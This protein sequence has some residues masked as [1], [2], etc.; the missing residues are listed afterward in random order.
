MFEIL[1]R[2]KMATLL[3]LAV[4]L[5]SRSA[6]SSC[7]AAADGSGPGGIH[8][9]PEREQEQRRFFTS[10][11]PRLGAKKFVPAAY[12]K[13][14]DG[15]DDDDGYDEPPHMSIANMT[16]D[17]FTQPLNHFVPRGKS[18]TFQQRYCV[19]D[20][21]AK[22][23]DDGSS[24]PLAPIL[25]Y[26]GNESPLEQY[27]NHTGLMWELAPQLKARVVFAEHRYEGQSLP[28]ANLTQDCMSYGSTMQALADYAD[29]LQLHLNSQSNID[30]DPTAIAPVIVFGGSYG[31]MLSAWMRMKYPHL[32]AGAI[33]ASAPIGGFP[34]MANHKMDG[35]ARVLAHGLQQS[36]PPDKKTKK[37]AAT[38]NHDI[39][40][41]SSEP[42][43]NHCG[44]NLLAAWPLITWLV[45]KNRQ[46]QHR[47]SKE[48]YH[49]ADNDDGDDDD[50]STFL[51]DVFCLCEP[52][53]DTDP[54][55]LIEFATSLW[56][57]LAE[58]S[59]PYPSSYIPFA[60]LHKKINLPA[61]PMQAAC[62]KS[63]LHQDWGISFQGREEGDVPVRYNISY[64]DSQLA[65]QIDWG[66]VTLASSSS[67]NMMTRTLS[68]S[69]DVVGLLTSV[70][71]AIGIWHNITKDVHCYNV[72]DAAP[73]SRESDYYSFVATNEEV[74]MMERKLRHS[75]P[76]RKIADDT[77]RSRPAQTCQEK[78]KEVGS[79]EPVCC[80]D[81]MN[82]IIT[83]A[84]G[85]GHDFFWPPS[86]PRDVNTYSELMQNV[87][88]GPCPDPDRIFGY[89]AENYDPWSTWLDTYYGS[90]R[91]TGHSNIIFSNGLLDPWAAGGIYAKDPFDGNFDDSS[92]DMV[93]NITNSD[94]IAL[95]IEYGGH[96]TDL[97][98]SH[99]LDPECVTQARDI[100]KKYILK[101][102]HDW[103]SAQCADPRA[104]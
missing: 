5:G 82:L 14:G 23:P 7:C 49:D 40:I 81:E 63:G 24:S 39:G 35:S 72:S 17:F 100:E 94:V 32:V 62:W 42:E 80:N 38:Y 37:K 60:L 13:G 69:K 58:G 33:A 66:N 68:T 84:H 87:T 99:E 75:S 88:I 93:Q 103:T 65:L 29:L 50:P 2:P 28:P 52:Y 57:D 55:P 97:M 41:D 56:F 86:L 46:R 15:E 6:T 67:K 89:S 70:R 74:T 71:E 25:F 92:P 96:H 95:L 54:E 27:I 83:E 104:C 61:W 3:S 91:M 101:W 8:H 44:S 22:S 9:H 43:E 20:E 64:G 51:Q 36:Y 76:R 78:I 4:V 48:G 21:Y 26:T 73:N 11:I 10:S 19:Y 77:T 79:W 53:T 34:Q 1:Y 59:F 30:K 90:S 18:P 45:Q 31:G 98:Y 85:L 102:I 12:P 47:H 16:C